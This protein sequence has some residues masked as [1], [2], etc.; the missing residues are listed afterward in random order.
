[1]KRLVRLIDEY[2]LQ[3]AIFTF[4]LTLVLTLPLSSSGFEAENYPLR[5]LTLRCVILNTLSLIVF[6]I[7]GGKKKKSLSFFP[8]GGL[9]SSAVFLLLKDKYSLTFTVS[10]TVTAVISVSLLAFTLIKVKFNGVD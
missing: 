4:F 5:I 3:I 7:F 6:S 2:F 1:M 10:F 9:L 8:L